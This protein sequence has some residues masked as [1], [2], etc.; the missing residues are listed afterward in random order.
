MINYDLWDKE[1]YKRLQPVQTELE[2]AG[3]PVAAI[4]KQA[5]VFGVDKFQSVDWLFIGLEGL[6]RETRENRQ[7]VIVNLVVR[8]TFDNRY[9]D[10]EDLYKAAY[11]WAEVEILKLLV[12]YRLPQ[13]R[14]E[15]TLENARLFAP[16]A[17]RWFK[18]IKFSFQ[19]DIYSSDDTKKLPE[20]LVKTVEIKDCA[21]NT[22]VGIDYQ[23]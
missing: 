7:S 13:T 20:N 12:L 17:G 21:Y 9:V 15:I 23:I 11:E 6:P 16:D 5:G 14:S 8:L 10:D 18:E 22:M 2:K 1:I 3:I 4:P 19:A